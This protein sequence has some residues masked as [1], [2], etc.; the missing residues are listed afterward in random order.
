MRYQL[1]YALTT[2]TISLYYP[3]NLRSGEILSIKAVCLVLFIK[4]SE[5]LVHID[6]FPDPCILSHVKNVLKMNN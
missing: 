6:D 2:L 1:F 5:F 4:L 3:I